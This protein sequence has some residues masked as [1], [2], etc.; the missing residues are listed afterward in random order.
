MRDSLRTCS[1]TTAAKNVSSA[2]WHGRR[3][4]ARAGSPS[5]SL[6]LRATFI[7]CGSPLKRPVLA[8]RRVGVIKEAGSRLDKS[9]R[10]LGIQLWIIAA[11][12]VLTTRHR[13]ED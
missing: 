12:Y 8:R 7:T 9:L 10:P 3:F 5:A 11:E 2:F 4:P 13:V 1:V 6:R